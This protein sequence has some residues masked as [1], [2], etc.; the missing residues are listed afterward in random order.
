MLN[1]NIAAVRA[2]IQKA[3]DDSGVNPA[4]VALLAVSKTF[5]A[6]HVRQ[7][8][9]AGLTEFGE[10][11]VQEGI[12]KI[13]ALA[14]LRDAITWHF[15][16]PLQSNKTRDVAEN[17]DW[18]H[19][20][21]RVKIARRLAEQRPRSLPPLQICIQV[22]VSG[23]DS[24][25]GVLPTELDALIKEISDIPQLALRG[26]MA[27]PEPTEDV[28]HQRQQFALLRELLISAK[29]SLQR[30]HPE[31]AR[32]FDVLSMGMSADLESAIQESQPGVTTMVRIGTAIFGRRSP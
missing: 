9:L 23:E 16:G 24:K 29:E 21:D 19:S 20:I 12:E 13:A 1:D 10:N 2:R 26:L 3:C 18:V 4:G 14:D 5:S 22:N 25:S 30:L 7:A 6:D 15:I 17:F 31:Q 8:F 32:H 27:I 11:Y 28:A